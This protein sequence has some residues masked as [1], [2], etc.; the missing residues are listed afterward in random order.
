MWRIVVDKGTR[1]PG[2]QKVAIAV[3][4]KE[5]MSWW[6]NTAQ[7]TVNYNWRWPYGRYTQPLVSYNW[8]SRQHAGKS[9]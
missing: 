4:L 7:C 1:V 6:K 3:N 5:V 2:R 8:K 9:G